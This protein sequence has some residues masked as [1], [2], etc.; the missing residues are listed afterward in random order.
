MPAPAQSLV[1]LL[2]AEYMAERRK[3]M[4]DY[5][6][7]AATKRAE[8]ARQKMIEREL[9]LGN[10]LNALDWL[11]AECAGRFTPKEQTT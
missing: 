9:E 7:P 4:V 5:A 6:I 1:P 11:D 8:E 10:L 2:S 3:W